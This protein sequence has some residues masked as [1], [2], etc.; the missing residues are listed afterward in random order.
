MVLVHQD[1]LLINIQKVQKV[2]IDGMDT[3]PG[4]C[5]QSTTCNPC[6]QR[7]RQKFM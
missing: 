5:G 2:N 3:R 4:S 7:S 1:K 6:E